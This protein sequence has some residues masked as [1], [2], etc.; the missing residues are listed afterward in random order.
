MSQKLTYNSPPLS[1][2]A[3]VTKDVRQQGI[4]RGLQ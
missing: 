3:A 2:A 1:P 4:Q